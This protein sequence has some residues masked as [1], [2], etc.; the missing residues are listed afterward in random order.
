MPSFKWVE[1]EKKIY[2]CED[3]VCIKRRIRDRVLMRRSIMRTIKAIKSNQNMDEIA[4]TL[5]IFMLK[6]KMRGVSEDEL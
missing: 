4:K 1:F 3:E 5:T 2:S 6:M